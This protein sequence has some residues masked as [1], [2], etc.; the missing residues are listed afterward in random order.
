MYECRYVGNV[1]SCR[2]PADLEV[3]KV[4]VE[5]VNE[6]PTYSSKAAKN[7]EGW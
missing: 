7:C 3:R 5:R 2:N 6:A 1:N 4:E